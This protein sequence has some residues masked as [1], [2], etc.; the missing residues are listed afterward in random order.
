MSVCLVALGSN[1]GDRR[2]T[3]DRAI[4]MLSATAGIGRVY[5]SRWQASS[6]IGGPAGQGEFLNGA[7]R[8][9]T[10]LAPHELLQT[11]RHIEQRL[12]RQRNQ[13]WAARTIDIDLLLFDQAVLDTPELIVP[14]P[15]LAFRRF[16]LA[17]AAEIGGDFV[18][19]LFGWTVAQLFDH[20]RHAPNV[21]AI[22]DLHDPDR[23]Q[24]LAMNLAAATGARLVTQAGTSLLLEIQQPTAPWHITPE[25][26]DEDRLAEFFQQPPADD[27]ACGKPLHPFT[28]LASVPKVVAIRSL[29][30]WPRLPQ[31][32]WVE[33]NPLAR[34]PCPWL[35][36]PES[37]DVALAELKAIIESM[38]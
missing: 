27:A 28:S 35:L 33:R 30:R 5:G 19:P 25:C 2:Q 13:R 3:L 6:P 37:Q 31:F 1:L 38:Q 20:L 16:V 7:A 32:P 8:L 24:Q 36:L 29:R 17:P 11:I 4:E 12:G 10:S 15:R 26:P 9:E 23:G 22:C 34:T 14:H 18:H 21:M